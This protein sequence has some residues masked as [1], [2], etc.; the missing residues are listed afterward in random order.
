MSTDHDKW[1]IRLAD[2]RGP[3]WYGAYVYGL[4]VAALVG[5]LRRRK[6]WD[7]ATASL[8]EV[9]TLLAERMVDGDKRNERVA[10]LTEQMAAMTE[11]G[12]IR[13]D[14]RQ[15]CRRITHRHARRTC[16][17]RGGGGVTIDPRIADWTDRIDG[18]L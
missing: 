8:T 7:D 5:T 9:G 16:R 14:E 2:V 11:H 12:A 1:G 6:A 18:A 10:E 13:P 15:A 4:I 17:S 3:S